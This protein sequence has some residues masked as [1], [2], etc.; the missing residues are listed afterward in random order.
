[1]SRAVSQASKDPIRLARVVDRLNVGGPTY[2]VLLLTR[3]LPARG[4]NPVLI[5]GQVAPFEAEMTSV[6][7][8]ISVDSLDIP[9]FTKSISLKD[10]KVLWTMYR[11]FR[12]LRPQIV[13]THKTKAGVVGRVAAFLAGVPVVVHTFHGHAFDGYFSRLANFVVL[14]IERVL[15]HWTDAVV[16]VSSQVRQSLISYGI[17][18]P[19]RIYTVPLGFDLQS[20]LSSGP[21]DTQFREELGIVVDTPLICSVGRLVP[22]KGLHVL[23]KAMKRVLDEIPLARLVVVGDG[24]SRPE[25]EKLAVDLG[26]NDQVIFTGFRDDIARIYASADL[27]VQSSLNE[28]SPVSLIEALA[29][30]CYVAAT[31]VGG[32]PDVVDSER[33]GLLV[34][35]GDDCALGDAIIC[36]LNEK[37]KVCASER[38][39]IG[40][41]YGIARLVTD[42]DNL[43]RILLRKKG[44]LCQEDVSLGNGKGLTT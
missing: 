4:Y 35:S 32:V 44:L 34:E 41:R 5:K 39:R 7:N 11:L 1:M 38:A 43:Y 20:F 24:E 2:H 8:E 21:F 18:S 42:L 17:A 13:H 3:D 30:G 31:A 36:S 14:V 23:L 28:G 15:A 12:S 25:L 6:I 33:L 29:S 22:I 27:V 16:T 10:A 40:L 19:K 26:I 37:R 9:G